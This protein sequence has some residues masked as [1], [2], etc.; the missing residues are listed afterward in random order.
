M[1]IGLLLAA[2][3]AISPAQ[4]QEGVASSCFHGLNDADTPATLPQCD[5]P[6]LLNVESNLDGTAMLKRKGFTQDAA[7]SCATCPVTGSH[8]FIDSSGNRLD[9]ICYNRY[10]AKK[11]NGNAPTDFL[12]TAASSAT[13]WSWVDQGGIAY[14]ANNAYDPIVKYDGT[15]LSRPAG[16][17]KGSILEL[18]SDRLVVSDIQTL[19][20]RV[21]LSSSGAFEQFTTGL[22]PEDSYFDDVGA[23][24]DKVRGMK[25]LDGILYIFK[26]ASITACEMGDQ[27]ST[28]CGVVSPSLGTTDPASIVAA[29][30]SIYFRAQDR[31]YWELSRGG[32]RQISKKIPNL[33]KSQSGGLAGGE[34]TNTQTTQADWNAGTQRPTGT[35]DTATLPGS[36][37]PSSVT[38]VDTSSANFAAGTLPES[39]TTSYA[40]GEIRVSSSPHIIYNGDWE[41][42]DKTFWTQVTL[43]GNGVYSVSGPLAIEGSYG[44]DC[45]VNATVTNS[46][47][48]SILDGVTAVHTVTYAQNPQ[49]LQPGITL[50]LLALGL[51]TRTLSI[52]FTAF[53]QDGGGGTSECTIRSTTFTAI[54][55]ITWRGESSAG[56][57]WGKLDAIKVNR[58]FS[59]YQS[60]ATPMTQ[61]SQVFDVGYST[62]TGGPFVLG[63]SSGAGTSIDSQVRSSAD[64]ST[65]WTAWTNISSGSRITQSLRYQQYLSTFTTSV[66][67]AAPTLREV[68]LS[69]ATTGQFIEQC[70]QPNSSISAWGTLSCAETKT[71]A[72]SIVYY[73][74]SA[75]TCAGLP[76]TDPTSWQ[77][78]ITNNATITISTNTA[79]KIGFRSLLGSATDQAQVDA[80]VITWNEGTPT[81]PSWAAYDSIKNAV[82]WTTTVNASSSTNRLLKYDL[83]LD[84]WYPL[85]IPA[86]APRVVNNVLYFGGASSGTWNQYGLVDSDN[87][88]AINA[89]WK[90]KDIGSQN[91]FVEKDFKTA[92]LLLRNN[93][94]GSVTGTYTYSNAETGAYTISLSTGAGINYARSNYRL[95]KTSPQNFINLKVGNNST[96]PFEILGFGLTWESKPWGVTGP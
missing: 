39:L 66:G 61:F 7:L 2:F 41:T 14:G 84:A 19:P 96:T 18:A 65:G 6:D 25:H 16:M 53:G 28:R 51:S 79:L 26:T 52:R 73:A 50:D 47:E 74:T 40:L 90:S 17:P 20:N 4:A 36:I 1:A 10:C 60:S 11:T 23:P 30:S 86:Q 33:V 54:S 48:V 85:D 87:G 57:G 68:S 62:P 75:V 77:T 49:I 37:F 63:L 89:Y 29:G 43:Q 35:W 94:A 83:N 58:Y 55:S 93:Q 44:A 70:V 67:T 81:Q 31:N 22:N 69:Y 5:S 38:L 59:H 95:P 24:G 46:A 21:H 76:T 42:G 91:P 12:T 56:F 34:Q 45:R 8:S 71:G 3:L 64:G 9:I 82:Y 88:Y 27:Y 32:L 72:G 80:C 13:R 92:S 78:S 15:T